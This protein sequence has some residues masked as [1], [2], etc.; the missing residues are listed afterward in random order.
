MLNHLRICHISTVHAGFDARVWERECAVIAK[1]GYDV[2]LFVPES[3]TN[4]YKDVVVHSLNK[5][6]SRYARFRYAKEAIKKVLAIEPVIIHFHDP[7]LIPVMLSVK[8]EM[9]GIKI[10]FDC[11]EDSISHIALKEYI[12]SFMR[13]LIE[14]TLTYYFKRAAKQFDAIVTADDGVHNIFKEWGANPITYF[15]YP[16]LEIYCEEPKSDY[17]QR[18]FDVI[19]PGSTPRYHLRL[20]FDIAKELKRRG[21]NTKWLIIAKLQF[22]D[23]DAW[24]KSNLKELCLEENFNFKP[25]VPLTELPRYLRTAR[26]G[27]IPLPDSPKFYRNIPSKLF[28]YFLAGLPVVLSDLPPSRPFIEDRNI[29]FAVSANDACAY[30][31]AIINLLDNPTLL[32]EMGKRARKIATEH[33]TLEKESN[34]LIDLYEDLISN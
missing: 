28:D 20:M 7:E 27:I 11:H 33:Y 31:D 10:V 29:A 6:Q 15:N 34:K 24:V 13:P 21:W 32:S 17:M 3:D 22:K 23:A 16:P 2:H 5:Y 19:Y 26:I 8:R 30:A 9:P 18:E 12:P 14:K 1:K 4:V 25:L